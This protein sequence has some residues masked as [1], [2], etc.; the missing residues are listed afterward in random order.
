MAQTLVL[1]VH[2][3]GGKAEATWGS[4]PNLLKSDRDLVHTE[5]GHFSY[6]TSLFRLPFSQRAPHVQ[7]L[8]GAL[9]TLLENATPCMTISFWCA[10]VWVG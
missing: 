10:T 2:G 9:Q 4:F 1:F 7:T 8:A 6:P 5:I 3:L